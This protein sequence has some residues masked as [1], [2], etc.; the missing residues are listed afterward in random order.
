[1]PDMMEYKMLC[2][3]TLDHSSNAVCNSLVLP[4]YRELH[5]SKM[6]LAICLLLLCTTFYT[7]ATSKCPQNIDVDTSPIEGLLET[8]LEVLLNRLDDMERKIL[9]LQIELNEHREDM[10]QNRIPDCVMTTSSTPLLDS[11]TPTTP[12]TTL[13]TVTDPP[14]Y[15]SC[16]AAPNKVS[17]VY[18]IRGNNDS[19]PFS[20]YCEQEKFGGGWIVIQQR[21][22]GSVDF[23]RNWEEYREGFGDLNKEFWL[24]LERIHQLTADRNYQIV[25]E[26]KDFLGY[27]GYARYNAFQVGS[28]SEQYRLKN[29][30]LY[31]GTAGDSLV[32]HKGMKFSTKDRDNDVRP[33]D[34]LAEY[35]Q[36]GWWYA[37][38][39]YSILNGPYNY[40]FDMRANWWFYFKNE[41]SRL[42]F[43]RMMIRE[44]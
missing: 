36:G 12:S 44:L 37:E 1:M 7:V 26:I 18:L 6:K 16:Y 20:V 14:S 33:G 39:N 11:K 10:E 3:K 21:F 25:I 24:G 15:A 42:T 8:M 19:D 5:S 23:N 9:E 43:T 40:T 32:Y 27:S 30:G 35:F 31:S 29:L 34:H 38:T 28:E 22:D 17:G 13:P 41:F 2:W 4:W